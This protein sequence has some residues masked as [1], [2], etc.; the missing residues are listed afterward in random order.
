MLDLP[1]QKTVVDNS[2]T[3][4]TERIKGAVGCVIAIVGSL[5][6]GEVGTEV[7]VPILRR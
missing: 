6:A 3:Q 4:T 2:V 5:I 1:V 7:S